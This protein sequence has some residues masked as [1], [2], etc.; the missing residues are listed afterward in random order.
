VIDVVIV[1]V[2]GC[3]EINSDEASNIA[4]I[5]SMYSKND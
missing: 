2:V 5:Y 4:E 1:V 3:G